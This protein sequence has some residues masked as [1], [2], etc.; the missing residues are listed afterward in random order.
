MK[1][2]S[3]GQIDS[4][5][6]KMVAQDHGPWRPFGESRPGS[7]GGNQAVGVAILSIPNHLRYW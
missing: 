7:T 2:P 6:R 5:M 1:V 4:P 3:T